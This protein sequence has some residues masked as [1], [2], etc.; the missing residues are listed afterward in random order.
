MTSSTTADPTRSDVA[1]QAVLDETSAAWAEGDAEAFAARYTDAATTIGP[2]FQ[3]MDRDA[4]RTTMAGAFAGPLHGTRRV[5]RVHSLRFLDGGTAIVVSDSRTAP[6]DD[7]DPLAGLR[8]W[9]T[10]VFVR[11]G[12]RWLIAAYHGC[13]Q[14][15]A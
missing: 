1:I 12:D 6:A 10:W 11:D 7:P 9:A 4:I 5:H 13:P 14:D 8:E 15:P 2:G 3:L